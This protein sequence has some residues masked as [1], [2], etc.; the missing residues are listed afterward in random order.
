MSYNRVTAVHNFCI[1]SSL[2]DKNALVRLRKGLMLPET[3]AQAGIPTI[4]VEEKMDKLIDAAL[5]DPCC[6]TNP[7]RPEKEMIRSILT[8]VTGRG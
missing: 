8:Q 1:I 5:S 2:V 4:A 7:L 6:R 3:L